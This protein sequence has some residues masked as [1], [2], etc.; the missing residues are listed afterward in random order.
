M[1]DRREFFAA[2]PAVALASGGV[3]SGGLVGRRDLEGSHATSLRATT[4]HDRVARVVRPIDGFGVQLYTLRVEMAEDAERTLAAIA[5]IGYR[6]VEMAGLYGLSPR[7]MRSKLDAVGLRAVSSHHGVGDVRGA[8]D[9]TLEGAQELGQ[10]LIV[11]PSIPGDERSAE[12]LRRIADD[13]NAAGYA[14]AEAGLRFGYHN[15][16]W[17]FEPFPDGTIPMDLLLERTSAD[18]V[19]WQMDIFWT[20]DG[21]ADP[22]TYLDRT[23]GRVTSVHVKDRTAIGEMVDVGDGVIDFSGLIDLAERHGMRH[24]FVEHDRPVDAVDSV[25]RSFQHLT[26]ARSDEA[27]SHEARSDEARFHDT[28]PSDTAPRTQTGQP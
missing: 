1:M 23:S 19:D 21:G 12:G 11:V 24:A 3:V 15:H 14:A 26:G 2:A 28:A 25:R 22:A 16:N 10:S 17:E 4:V 5:E 13:F 8:W 7:E 9:R 27:R 18:V 20:V 6:E